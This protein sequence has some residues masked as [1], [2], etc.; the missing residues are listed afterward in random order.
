ML[1]SGVDVLVDAGRDLLRHFSR[2]SSA[3]ADE[4]IAK[5]LVSKSVLLR[6]LAVWGVAHAEWLSADEKLQWILENDL[7]FEL[8]LKTEVF[9]VLA[10]ALESASTSKRQTLLDRA[11][12]GPSREVLPSRSSEYEIYNVLIWINEHAPSDQHV[13]RALEEVRN[14]NPDFVPRPNPDLHMWTT[15]ELISG[16]TPETV[17]QLLSMDPVDESIAIWVAS[18]QDSPDVLDPEHWRLHERFAGAATQ[19][20]RWAVRL[21]RNLAE[22]ELWSPGTWRAIINGLTD[23]DLTPSDRMAVLQV[24]HSA[25]DKTGFAEAIPRLLLSI[26]ERN[27][28]VRALAVADRLSDETWHTIEQIHLS[29]GLP[30]PDWLTDAINQSGGQLTQYWLR[31]LSIRL[32]GAQRRGMP[33]A[34]IR[35]FDW[36]LETDGAAAEAGRIVLAS[37]AHFLL[38]LDRDWWR[39]KLNP[40]FKWGDSRR[41]EQVWDGYLMWVRLNEGLIEAMLPNYV[42]TFALLDTMP[43]RWLERFTE[44]LAWIALFSARDPRADGWLAQFVAVTEPDTRASWAAHVGHYLRN[45]SVDA[46]H[47]WEKWL[48][49]YWTDR[50]NGLPRMLEP[51]EQREM[52]GWVVALS[53]VFQE[54]V[55][56]YI[57]GPRTTP[58]GYIWSAIGAD[59]SDDEHAQESA[60]FLLALLEG[61]GE[62][63]YSCHEAVAA[64]AKLEESLPS[65]ELLDGIRDRL[66]GLGCIQS[67]RHAQP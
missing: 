56:L 58:R 19:D 48:R 9:E 8:P 10:V 26:A 64:F 13:S 39:F 33:R 17:E 20:P 29:D 36:L 53:E 22:R 23:V 41:A 44:H 54:A 4:L 61:Q 38:A 12:N 63:F 32:R 51:D 65:G 43:D 30:G 5:W 35:R 6:R 7:L 49:R 31:S 62:P 3:D 21:L 14:R 25:R 40:L 66:L 34:W 59:M 52:A 42:A 27:P 47:V 28:S 11:V 2:A 60:Q 46:S 18:L 16:S 15:S 24:L 37:Q 67:Q 57:A 1:D 55:R 45:G 50:T